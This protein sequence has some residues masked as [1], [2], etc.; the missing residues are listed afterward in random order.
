[1]QQPAHLRLRAAREALGLSDAEVAGRTGLALANYADLET[2]PDATRQAVDLRHLKRVCEVLALDLWELLGLRCAYCRGK[3]TPARELT[4]PARHELIRARRDALGFA[5][6]ALAARLDVRL[7]AIDAMV[8]DPNFLDTWPAAFV[9]DLART[10]EV[11][12]QALLDVPCPRC[13]R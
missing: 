8:R 4:S 2:S 5:R 13:W 10:L 6:D 1:M 9:E 7:D 3:G 12:A 11:P